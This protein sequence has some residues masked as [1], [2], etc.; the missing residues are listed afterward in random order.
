GGRGGAAGR[1]RRARRRRPGG[2]RPDQHLDRRVGNAF[3]VRRGWHSRSDA[4]CAR[5]T[6]GALSAL[7]GGCAEPTA[8]GRDEP[9]P[10]NTSI[11]GRTTLFLVRRGWHSRSDACCA[12]RT[13]GALSALRGG[14]GEPIAVGRDEPGPTN[15]STVGRTTLFLSAEAGIPG[16]MR[17]ALG[18][19]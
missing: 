8:A 4:C 1:V 11:V 13:G 9:G 10:K 15:T 3:L 16:A 17:V 18:G 5:R 7:R 2:T 6:G 14:C 19:Q 12:R